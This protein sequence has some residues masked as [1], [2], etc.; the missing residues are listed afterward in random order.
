MQFLKLLA[1]VVNF[2]HWGIT[3]KRADLFSLIDATKGFI[4]EHTLSE[5]ESVL[6]M[7]SVCVIRKK[8]ES[9]VGLGPRI[10]SGTEA[11]VV[12]EIR[13]SL[14]RISTP[15]SQELNPFS[16]PSDLSVGWVES[17]KRQNQELAIQNQLL[18]SQRDELTFQR[19]ELGAQLALKNETIRAIENTL[20]WRATRPLRYLRSFGRRTK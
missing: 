9:H 12:D 5:I 4:E 13:D 2:D 20:S 11:I 17:L 7:D 3:A 10:G 6:F 19:D 15:P 18:K 8:S 1:D 16:R 14:G